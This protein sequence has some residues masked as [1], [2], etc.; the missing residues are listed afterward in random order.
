MAIQQAYPIP[1]HAGSGP[2]K[3][4]TFVM[5]K[6]DLELLDE[7]VEKFPA[8]MNRSD[9]MREM[10]LPYVHA[11][12]A[13]KNGEEFMKHIDEGAGLSHLRQLIQDAESDA[14]PVYSYSI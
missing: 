3:V 1:S 7:L 13:A 9:V 5:K 8:H 11:L 6:D 12:R 10:I 14:Q 2:S 4:I